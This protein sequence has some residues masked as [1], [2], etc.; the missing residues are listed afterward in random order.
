[1]AAQGWCSVPLPAA[2][3]PPSYG[4]AAMSTFPTCS[5]GV[6]HTWE[7]S[8]TTSGALLAKE[9]S[10]DILQMAGPGREAMGVFKNLGKSSELR[11]TP[12]LSLDFQSYSPRSLLTSSCG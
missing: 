12:V 8:A 2:L 3:L 10:F 1:M 11:P 6:H 9:S 5:M 7:H 4:S